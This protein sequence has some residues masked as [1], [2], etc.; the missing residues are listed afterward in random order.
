MIGAHCVEEL[1]RRAISE[2]MRRY[3][4]AV[5]RMALAAQMSSG[6]TALA[7]ET[8]RLTAAWRHLL[9]LHV[10]VDDHCAGC[11]EGGSR[12]LCT[13]WRISNGFVVRDD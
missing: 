1:L 13:V 4:A 9:E 11:M 12:V 10:P 7:V 5:D 2:H 6:F 3:L 8:Q